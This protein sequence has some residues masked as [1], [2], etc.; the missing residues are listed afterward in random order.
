[1]SL[2]KDIEPIKTRDYLKT[3]FQEYYQEAEITLPP[4]FTSREWGFLDW[5]GRGMRRH[6]KFNSFNE[7]K[8]YLQ[9]NNTAH[10]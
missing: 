9:K 1:M 3:K 10:C 5:N 7:V 2:L 6:V 8:K 4:R